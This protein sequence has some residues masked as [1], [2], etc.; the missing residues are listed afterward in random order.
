VVSLPLNVGIVVNT[1]DHTIK[2]VSAVIDSTSDG[3]ATLDLATRV[4]QR[5][6]AI[7]KSSGC[8]LPIMTMRNFRRCSTRS[9]R[10]SLKSTR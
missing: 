1:T 6:G 7:S 8:Q 9:L 4:A 10:A 3:W 2:W 5:R